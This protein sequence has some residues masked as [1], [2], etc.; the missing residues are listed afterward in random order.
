MRSRPDSSNVPAVAGCWNCRAETSHEA[1]AESARADFVT[2]TPAGKGA[3]AAPG[4]LQDGRWF[5]RGTD[6]ATVATVRVD[7]RARVRVNG[8][9]G[10]PKRS[11]DAPAF[12]DGT[13]PSTPSRATAGCRARTRGLTSMP[14][15]GASSS[16][17][18]RARIRRSLGSR[19]AAEEQ[20]DPVWPR[21]S[22][23]PAA[24]QL[25]ARE[26]PVI[27]VAE[28]PLR[29]ARVIEVILR[30]RTPRPRSA[31]T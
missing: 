18:R 17:S 12:R 28:A 15:R 4:T 24:G 22:I 2:E 29:P 21:M 13:I 19:L 26:T 6:G 9:R 25:P 5:A 8:R 11:D 30:C 14:A 20:N 31:G 3:A 27:G 10:K 1:D 16:P 7:S 23:Q